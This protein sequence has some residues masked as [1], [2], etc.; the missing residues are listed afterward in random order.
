MLLW[1]ISFVTEP[2]VVGKTMPYFVACASSWSRCAFSKQE[3]ALLDQATNAT[4]DT[5]PMANFN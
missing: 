4:E 1:E 2:T 5:Y 3:S